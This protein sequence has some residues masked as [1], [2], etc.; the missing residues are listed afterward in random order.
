MMPSGN[1]KLKI[2]NASLN[3]SQQTF[4]LKEFYINA[5]ISMGFW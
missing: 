5:L 2:K 1:N 3:I 4:L